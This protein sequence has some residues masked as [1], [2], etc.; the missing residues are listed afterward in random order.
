MGIRPVFGHATLP[1]IGQKLQGVLHVLVEQMV[2]LDHLRNTRV[3]RHRYAQGTQTK[4]ALAAV[5]QQS[6]HHR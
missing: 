4:A 1:G 6:Q 3:L 2:V 5:F